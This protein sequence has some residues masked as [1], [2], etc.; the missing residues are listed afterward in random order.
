MPHYKTLSALEILIRRGIIITRIKPGGHIRSLPA[1]NLWEPVC[2]QSFII[3]AGFLKVY[4]MIWLDDVQDGLCSAM[5]SFTLN[6]G[7]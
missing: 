2:N 7:V 4:L 3:I 1:E 5:M 6:V